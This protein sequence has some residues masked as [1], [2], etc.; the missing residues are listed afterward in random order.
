MELRRTVF[1]Y[2]QVAIEVT[3]PADHLAWLREFL[4]PDFAPTPDAR[5]SHHVVLSIDDERCRELRDLGPAGGDLAVFVMDSGV[6]SYPRWTPGAAATRVAFDEGSGVFYLRSQ[7]H[8]ELL[9]A[10]NTFK[11]RLPLLRT[12]RELATRS[13]GRADALR[14]HAA[15]FR[16]GDEAALILGP[17][18]AGKTSLLVHALHHPEVDYV[19][20]DRTVVFLDPAGHHRARGLPTIL[21]LRGD[22]LDRYPDLRARILADRYHYAVSLEEAAAGEGPDPQPRSEGRHLLSPRQF[23]ELLG[24][25]LGGTTPLGALL[26]PELTHAAGATSLESIAP[27]E[28]AR[29]LEQNLFARGCPDPSPSLFEESV[30]TNG[31]SLQVARCRAIA[32]STPAYVAK[33]GLEVHTSDPRPWIDEVLAGRSS[34]GR[35]AE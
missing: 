27:E 2:E 26:F 24:T 28:A 31:Q 19:S 14:M 8:V 23:G 35:V 6:L 5:P 12:V 21:S 9:A 33:L 16:R 20:N 1:S 29:R 11:L 17:K 34:A 3:A 7:A 32:A 15:C 22:M 30:E 4:V 25:T 10:A 13:L 18:R